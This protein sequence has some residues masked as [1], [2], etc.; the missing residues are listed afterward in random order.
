[1]ITTFFFIIISIIYNIFISYIFFNKAHIRSYEIKIFGYLLITNLIGLF[2]ELYNRISITYI[3]IDN[4]LTLIT[5]KVY[6]F[7]YII[8]I[9]FFFKY[10][11]A[12]SFSNKDYKKYSKYFNFFSLVTLLVSFYIIYKLPLQI[13][14]DMG[15]YL[16][17]L[18]VET[19]FSIMSIYLI[20]I[21]LIYI[22][23]YKHID[24]N[25]YIACLSF[26]IF[27]GLFGFIQKYFPFITLST[28]MQTIVLYIMY[29]T[30]EN[31]DAKMLQQVKLAKLLIENTNN[32]KNDLINNIS[33]EIRNP[34]NSIINFSEDIKKYELPKE[35]NEDLEYIL[36]S[37]N[38]ILEV[39]G[40]SGRYSRTSCS[41]ISVCPARTD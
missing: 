3:G 10:F 12:I 4:P 29:N 32:T 5:C 31:P 15:I 25:K 20:L 23:R 16:S 30:I 37:S 38:N 21:I 41:R 7:Y 39:V 40:R 19:V 24:K 2:L 34:L 13:N 35:V 9:V 8:Y 27:S 33:Q 28:S 1:M 14:T 11:L 17:G 6:L 26:I 22:F 18:A 36:E